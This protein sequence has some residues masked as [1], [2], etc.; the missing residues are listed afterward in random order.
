M[1]LEKGGD[2]NISA[3]IHLMTSVVATG[4]SLYLRQEVTEGS[5]PS[6]AV[7][8]HVDMKGT[9]VAAGSRCF[10]SAISDMGNGN[11]KICFT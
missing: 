8:S 6:S 9:P 10:S 5:S 2:T 1:S 7:L 11:V 3:T 4:W